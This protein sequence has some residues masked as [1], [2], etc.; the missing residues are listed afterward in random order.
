M[1]CEITLPAS[2]PIPDATIRANEAP[3]NTVSLLTS[4]SAANNMVAN[5]V[6]SPSSAI[7][8][9]VK[10]VNRTLYSNLLPLLLSLAMWPAE[11]QGCIF[12]CETG[13]CGEY[14]LDYIG[15]SLLDTHRHSLLSRIITGHHFQSENWQ[16]QQRPC[17]SIT[18]HSTFQ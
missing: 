9:A 15:S 5:C 4:L 10:T 12:A 13:S 3:K 16:T 17:Q 6:L 2:T 1:Y 11:K 7:K 8:T 18:Q 14:Y